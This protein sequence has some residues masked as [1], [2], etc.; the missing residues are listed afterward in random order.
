MLLPLIST[1]INET[2]D[3]RNEGAVTL[4]KDQGECG[5]CW[6]FKKYSK[7]QLVQL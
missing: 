1:D 3:W 4:V 7:S 6:A 5:S 2:V